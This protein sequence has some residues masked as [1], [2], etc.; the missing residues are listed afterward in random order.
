M[1]LPHWLLFYRQYLCDSYSSFSYLVF[2][3]VLAEEERA[4]V[5]KR[6]M[7]SRHRHENLLVR[8]A[9]VLALQGQTGMGLA[10]SGFALIAANAIGFD[11]A[12]GVLVST[13]LVVQR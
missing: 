10:D 6:K 7:R 2:S 13:E 8:T 9:R 5:C 11:V 1:C 4:T 3:A 12:G